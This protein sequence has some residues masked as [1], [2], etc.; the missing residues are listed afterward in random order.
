MCGCCIPL[1]GQAE[2]GVYIRIAC[3]DEADLERAAHGY[4][5]AVAEILDKGIEARAPVRA[6]AHYTY[7]LRAVLRDP[8]RLRL[9]PVGAQ[10]GTAAFAA[11][12]GF[13]ERLMRQISL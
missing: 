6:A 1:G 10:L 8:D 11:H 5:V 4:E 9:L 7:R 2:T 12:A 13:A 3:C